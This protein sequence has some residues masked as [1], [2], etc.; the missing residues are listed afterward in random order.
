MILTKWSAL[1]RGILSLLM[2]GL[3]AAAI[4]FGASSSGRVEAAP[5][6]AATSLYVSNISSYQASFQWNPSGWGYTQWLDISHWNGSYWQW[7]NAGPFGGNDSSYT[8]SGLLANTTYYA[9]VNTGVWT[10]QWLATDWVRFDT[11]G[12]NVNCYGG[13]P[14]VYNQQ[15]YGQGYLA[16][17]VIQCPPPQ[18]SAA[19]QIWTDRG[20]GAR[21]D[22][23]DNIKVCYSVSMPMYVQIIDKQ[24][25]GQH[26]LLSGYDDG[27]GDCINAYITPPRGRESITIYGQGGASDTTH[28]RVR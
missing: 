13:G 15:G 2:A 4:S 11:A 5:L 18:Q 10:G 19:V 7:Q 20:E 6:G 26:T 3:V 21:Y 27:R 24:D 1:K 22:V 9:R 25:N 8:W 23:G 16:P 17:Q 28:F 14:G 12:S